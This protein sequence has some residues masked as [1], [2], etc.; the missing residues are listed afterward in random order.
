MTRPPFPIKPM[1]HRVIELG[2]SPVSIEDKC[3]AMS[4]DGWR[5]VST[6]YVLD[7]MVM[8]IFRRPRR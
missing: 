1:E 8:G 7:Y 3:N 6:Y 4:D 5:L 2:R